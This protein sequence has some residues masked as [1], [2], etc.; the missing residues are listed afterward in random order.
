MTEII[1]PTGA[2]KKGIDKIER[3]AH[4]AASLQRGIVKAG[5]ERVDYNSARRR[6]K[7]IS[8][9]FRRFSDSMARL[10]SMR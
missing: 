3:L 9:I 10:A 6:H 5:N 1:E 4:G 8:F 7:G 2:S